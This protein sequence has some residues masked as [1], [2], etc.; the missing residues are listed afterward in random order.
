[1]SSKQQKRKYGER[2]EQAT[3][4]FLHSAYCLLPTVVLLFFALCVPA[5]AQTVADKAVAIADQ[6]GGR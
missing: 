3:L 1:M 2:F 4:V 6:L 5:Q